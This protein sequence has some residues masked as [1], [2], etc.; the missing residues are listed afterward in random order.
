MARGL[1]ALLLF[2]ACSSV[3]EHGVEQPPNVLFIL[4]DDMGWADAAFNFPE[5]FYE[6]PNVDRLAQAGTVLSAAYAAAPVWSPTRAS[7]LTGRFPA[8]TG[9]TD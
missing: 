3:P 2:A 4:V 6:T 9:A 8:R 7:T 5:T 1:T